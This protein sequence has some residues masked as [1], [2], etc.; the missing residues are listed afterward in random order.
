M[1]YMFRNN[2]GFQFCF[3]A[4]K[5]G[6]LGDVSEVHGVMS[7]TTSARRRQALAQYPGVAMYELG[8][9]LIDRLIAINDLQPSAGK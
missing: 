2:S 9:H 4:V 3:D 8:G 7:K 5:K 1:G 6:W